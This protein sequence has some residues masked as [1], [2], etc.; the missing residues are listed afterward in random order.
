MLSVYV[1]QCTLHANYPPLN[2]AE[3][4]DITTALLVNKLIIGCK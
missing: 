3:P 2:V 4:P 1:Q